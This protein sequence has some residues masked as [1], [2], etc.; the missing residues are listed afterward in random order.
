M[1]L[2]FDN[3]LETPR[4]SLVSRSQLRLFSLIGGL[5]LVGMMMQVAQSPETRRKLE[6]IFGEPPA[7]SQGV[8]ALPLDTRAISNEGLL[9]GV[10]PELLATVEDNTP[11]RDEETD[12]WFHL[13]EIARQ[14]DRVALHDASLGEVVY[15]QLVG[16]PDFYR[17]RVVTVLGIVRRIEAIRP[18][19]NDL[20]ID[21]LYRVLVQ[22]HR[23]GRLP[24]TIYCMELPDGWSVDM[25]TGAPIEFT[26]F[27]FKNWV[28]GHQQGIDLSPVLLAHSFTPRVQEASEPSTAPPMPIWQLVALAGLL[29]GAVIALIW[30]NG[31]EVPQP[32]IPSDEVQ[33]VAESLHDLDA[34]GN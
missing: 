21:Q 17:G 32:A 4:R 5:V 34:E 1:P 23:D 30:V 3:L 19:A 14:A 24:L 20:G 15:A 27:F 26:G 7:E 29:A 33:A 6:L 2:R 22:P 13:L 8:V 11:F 18:A 9:E 28:Y 31:R 25:P 12:A 10:D 16:Q